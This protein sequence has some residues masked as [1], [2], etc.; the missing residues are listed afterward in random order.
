[1]SSGW[2]C[3]GQVSCE[4]GSS[5]AW[6]R[7][8]TGT[9]DTEQGPHTWLWTTE[10]QWCGE[11]PPPDSGLAPPPNPQGHLGPTVQAELL[12]PLVQEI[13]PRMGG[14]GGPPKRA[15]LSWSSPLKC[16]QRIVSFLHVFVCT[17]A[18]ASFT[19]ATIPH[20]LVRDPSVHTLSPLLAKFSL[21]AFALLTF[22][23]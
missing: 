20:S 2:P 23:A 18:L 17:M 5:R 6:A 13:D 1:M 7:D 9:G 8:A 22:S 15:H 3:A 10:A 12:S 11:Q 19:F 14:S 16:L 4:C 21:N